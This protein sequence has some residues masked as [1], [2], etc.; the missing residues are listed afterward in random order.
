MKSDFLPS[1]TND[2]K[3]SKMENEKGDKMLIGTPARRNRPLAIGFA[4][5]A[6]CY[7]VWSMLPRFSF[8]NCMN[9]GVRLDSWQSVQSDK[10][11]VPLEAHIMSKCPDA[12]VG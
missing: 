7:F 1:V 11:L 2:I 10:A 3:N 12:Q 9:H 4:A 5:I 6:F 8:R